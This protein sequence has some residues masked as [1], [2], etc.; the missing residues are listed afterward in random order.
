[1]LDMLIRG[2]RVVSESGI[3][4]RSIAITDGRVAALISGSGEPQAREVVDAADCLVLPGIVD[5][6]V[7]FREPG[8]THKE[9]FASGSRAA[10]A[11]GV[12]TVMV[13][14]TD[15]PFTTTPETFAEKIAIAR[16]RT[17]VDFALQAGLGTSRQHVR[18][19]ADLGAVS[20]EI[21]MSDLP[22]SLLLDDPA[23]LIASL[24]AVRDVARVAGVTPGNESLYRRA[25][26]LARRAFGGSRK[27]FPASRP[28]EAEALG[29]AVAC[30]AASLSG[31]RTHL[32]QISCAASLAAL[33]AF[34]SENVTVEVTPHN[35]LLQESDFLRLGPV[36]KVAPPLR[37]AADLAA[38]RLAMKAGSLDVI[39]TDHAPHHPSEK[40]RAAEDIW[41]GPGG[42]PGVQTFLPLMLKLVE[43]EILDY[44]GL[45]RACCAAPARLFGL[46]PRKGALQ[47]GSDA[48][49]VIVDPSRGMTIRNHDQLSKA[50]DVPFDGMSVPATPVLATL[51]GIVIMRDGRPVGPSIGRFVAPSA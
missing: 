46:Y 18:A 33:A 27:S 48:D 20:F 39:A 13:M 12:T 32:R 8:L 42:F 29:T 16:G 26:E 11:G 50:R 34:R 35:L 15:D 17:H 1:M 41:N 36:A 4:V 45:V 28:P 30:I 3:E 22:P 38:M 51:R 9:D 6:H 7:H 25:A 23:E 47:T 44:P 10:A 40:A 37:P 2:G 31:A 24:E 14:P 49:L 5:S 19:L 21:F 43:E